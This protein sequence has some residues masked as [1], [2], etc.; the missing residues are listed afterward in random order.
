LSYLVF[1]N[2]EKGEQ[3]KFKFIIGLG[4]GVLLSF[5]GAQVASADSGT[6]SDEVV[7]GQ[8]HLAPIVDGNYGSY[9]TM[10]REEGISPEAA[11]A[12]WGGQDSEEAYDDEIRQLFGSDLRRL[13]FDSNHNMVI[14]TAKPLS[15]PERELLQKLATNTVVTI[16]PTILSQDAIGDVTTDVFYKLIA[17]FQVPLVVAPDAWTNDLH[18]RV[19]TIDFSQSSQGSTAMQAWVSTSE[20]MNAMQSY[21]EQNRIDGVGISLQL[22]ESF[23]A[24]PQ[25]AIY[26]SGGD[27]PATSLCKA[28]F[29][30]SGNNFSGV[31]TTSHCVGLIP[32]YEGNATTSGPVVSAQFGDMTVLKIANSTATPN[33]V[34]GSTS[35]EISRIATVTVG[36]KICFWHSGLTSGEQCDTVSELNTCKLSVDGRSACQMDTT[37]R[38]FSVPGDSGSGWY[39]NDLATGV[40]TAYGVH[41]GEYVDGGVYHSVFS[42]TSSLGAFGIHVVT[43][44]DS[45]GIN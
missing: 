39:F 29:A 33:F 19:G 18:V 21:F 28:A 20:L 38:A 17:K 45:I 34:T 35:I 43:T 42:P 41:W 44:A 23:S 1:F 30:V 25:S 6:S 32:T 22:D 16:D 24:I 13:G 7:V 26:I 14:V 36:K 9:G 27:N 31:I 4:V 11:Y 15:S 8:G 5:L 2:F 10:A 40:V 3:M 12:E 37:N